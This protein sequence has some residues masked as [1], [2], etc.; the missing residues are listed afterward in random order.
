MSRKN[1]ADITGI[2]PNTVSAL[3]DESV[4]RLDVDMLNNLCKAFNCPI[5]D[6]LEYIP[7]EE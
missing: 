4:K 2:R 5:S 3:Y 1:L 6:I 7:D